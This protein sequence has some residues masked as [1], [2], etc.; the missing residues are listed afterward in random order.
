MIHIPASY[1]PLVRTRLIEANAQ[2]L[3]LSRDPLV[4]SLVVRVRMRLPVPPTERELAQGLLDLVSAP[5]WQGD[6]EL[7]VEKGQWLDTDVAHVIGV[8][9]DCIARTHALL[10]L[11]YAA[12]LRGRAE[13]FFEPGT[14]DHVAAMLLADGNW[15]WADPL[16]PGATLGVAPRGRALPDA[17]GTVG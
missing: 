11:A 17:R 6:T 7:D 9:G 16:V 3:S 10:A 15:W 1:S 5:D 4:Q 2:R 12:G 13:W 14:L 8:G